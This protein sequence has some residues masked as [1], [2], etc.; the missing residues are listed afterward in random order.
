M[1]V[2]SFGA[3]FSSEE[4]CVK[5]FKNERD[6]IGVSCKCG[7]TDFFWI[8]SRLSYECKSCNKRITLRSGTILEN[9]N[10]S[11]LVWY[12]AIFLMSATKKGFSARNAETIRLE[13]L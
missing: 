11:F 8:K 2:F 10:L 6:K 5:H 4:D 12:K 13:A 7:K 1:N 9:S 3:E